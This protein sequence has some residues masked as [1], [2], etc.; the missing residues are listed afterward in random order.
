MGVTCGPS[1]DPSSWVPGEGTS[2]L[3]QRLGS[4]PPAPLSP[5][6]I[7]SFFFSLKNEKKSDVSGFRE[8]EPRPRRAPWD[9]GLPSPCAVVAPNRVGMEM[10]RWLQNPSRRGQDNG[11]SGGRRAA[12]GKVPAT[13]SERLSS[14]RKVE[15]RSGPPS[16]PQDPPEAG[17]A[18]S[19]CRRRKEPSPECSTSRP[20]RDPTTAARTPTH[21]LRL[22]RAPPPRQLSRGADTL[23][24]PPPGGPPDPSSART[25]PEGT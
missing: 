20:R 9:R 5:S 12:H 10:R 6:Q 8:P 16:P 23:T 11:P 22:C 4:A 25:F 17:L 14:Q 1:R 2:R 13:S 7:V 19:V 15:T 21:G 18:M 3:E 24:L